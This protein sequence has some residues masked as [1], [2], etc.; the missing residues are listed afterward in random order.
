MTNFE[1]R[2][3]SSDAIGV[4]TSPGMSV[5]AADA[6]AEAAVSSMT[7]SFLFSRDS[8]FALWKSTLEVVLASTKKENRA[9]TRGAAMRRSCSFVICFIIHPPDCEGAAPLHLDDGAFYRSD[10]YN[11]K[12]LL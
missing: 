10:I 12:H 3:A 2:S 7:L 9:N 11:S 6:A 1:L 5:M 4:A 8:I